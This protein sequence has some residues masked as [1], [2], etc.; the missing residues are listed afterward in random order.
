MDLQGPHCI[1][2]FKKF[3]VGTHAAHISVDAHWQRRKGV[4][5][6]GGLLPQ[7]GDPYLLLFFY[8]TESDC[9]LSGG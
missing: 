5:G 7:A 4:L 8:V 3:R 6:E 1:A 2:S 9:L